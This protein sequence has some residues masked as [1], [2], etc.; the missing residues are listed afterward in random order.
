MATTIHVGNLSFKL[1]EEDL[2]QFFSKYGKVT[3]T[4]VVRRGGRPK[5]YGFVE[6][7]S[8]AAADNALAA[9]G[10]SLDER[11]INIEKAKGKIQK[12]NFSD[13]DGGE[14]RSFRGPRRDNYRNDNYRGGGD[15]YRGDNYRQNYR[16]DNYRRNDRDDNRGDEQD[17]RRYSPQRRDGDQRKDGG[18]QRRERD[19][20]DQRRERDVEQRRDGDDGPRRSFNS[21]NRFGGR[22]RGGRV[23]Y[24]LRPQ[25]SGFGGRRFNSGFGRG[26][27]R[28]GRR[29]FNQDRPQ[30]EK[31]KTDTTVYVSN[32]PFSVDDAQLAK[33][34]NKYQ[35]K[36]T[37]IVQS[38]SGRSRGYG[39]VEFETEQDQEK[40]II[41]M[42]DT[43]V[44][45]SDDRNRK[46]TVKV[47]L[48]EKPGQKQTEEGDTPKT[49]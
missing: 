15:N 25:Q 9:N 5:G 14:R 37:H 28:G 22:S 46:I 45:G 11:N 47:A 13:N 31:E 21:P 8:S 35:V 41:E 10:V 19:G 4:Y 43:E 34:F 27:N 6:F 24:S 1:Q 2:K 7:D 33:I 20:G 26:G 39:F 16:N 18:D 40:A 36:T 38:L 30:V 44:M 48:V 17:N 32:L 12:S 23:L 49:D 3:D 42:N 29:T